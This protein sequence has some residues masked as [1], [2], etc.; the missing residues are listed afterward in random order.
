MRGGECWMVRSFV[1]HLVDLDCGGGSQGRPGRSAVPVFTLGPVAPES[2]L[3]LL[4]P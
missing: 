3:S 4:S 2:P 1:V